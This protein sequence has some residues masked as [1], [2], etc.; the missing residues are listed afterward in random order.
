[1]NNYVLFIKEALKKAPKKDSSG[2][3]PVSYF[4]TQS[5]YLGIRNPDKYKIGRQFKKQFPEISFEDLIEL[6]NELAEGQTFEEKTMPGFMIDRY[7]QHLLHIQP[8][9]LDTWLSSL[10]GWCEV[11]SLCQSTF[12][13]EHLLANGEEWE[14]YLVKFSH[15]VNISKRRASLV[16]LCKPVAQ[17]SEACLKDLSFEIIETLKHETSPLITKAISWLLRQMVENHRADVEKYLEINKDSLPK[18]ALRET[19]KVL[20]TGK[21]T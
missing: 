21:K 17:S 3:N 10:T 12:P 19:R 14:K 8:A 15:D 16:L 20:L 1:M 2:F 18:L 13:A 4:G 6:F 7:P 11:D 9:H 5:Q